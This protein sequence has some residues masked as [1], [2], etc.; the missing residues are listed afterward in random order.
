MASHEDRLAIQ[1][2]NMLHNGSGGL[3]WSGLPLACALYGVSDVE[4]LLHRL[5]II[6]AHR[7]PKE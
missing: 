2:H 7:P 5:N 1:I 3:D 6:R 4:P